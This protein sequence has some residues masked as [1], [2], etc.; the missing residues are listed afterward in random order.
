[1]NEPAASNLVE[2][3]VSEL[4]GALKVAIEDQFGYVRVRGEVSGYRGPHGSGHVYFSIK[5]ASAKI[6]AVIWRGVFAR[7]RVKPQEGMEVIASG[8]ITTFP[9]KS[10]YQILV[11]RIEP[12]GIGALMALLEDRRRRLAA[13]GLFDA[14]RKQ[15]IPY[16][17]TIVGVITSPS[18]AVI[19]DIL[20][21]IADRFPRRVLIWPV[22]VQGETSADEIVA[23]LAGFNGLSRHGPVPRPDVLILA[24]GGGSLEDLLSFNDEGVV[25][26]AAD[27]DIP[28]IAAVGHESDWTLVDYAADLRAPTPTGAA[29]MCV[30]VRSELLHKVNDIGRR[31]IAAGLRDLKRRRIELRS[32]DRLLPS[33]DE[34][35]AIPRQRFDRAAGRSAAA[36]SNVLTRRRATL[37][38]LAARL[39]PY[40]P[41]TRLARLSERLS[42]LRASLARAP[43]AS[44]ASRRH[45][46]DV[47]LARFSALL[48]GRLTLA[49][50]QRQR[51]IALAGRLPA[52]WS[53]RLRGARATSDNLGKLLATLG[54]RHVLAR[55]FVL[56]RD[57]AGRPLRLASQLAAEER[58]DLEFS[59]GHVEAIVGA[60][61]RPVAAPAP[62]RPAR[63][64]DQ[65]QGQLF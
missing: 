44:L 5:D 21:R 40:A 34:L 46:Q 2:F 14:A 17:P 53:A 30:P 65:G 19:R 56:V 6:D 10:S 28:L 23:A 55:G 4:A 64:P 58:L 48:R 59:D 3:T 1:M 18:G 15:L 57:T 45:R 39:A 22:R 13:E 12:A 32:A 63:P 37:L 60:T 54:Y 61:A 52:A 16:L 38:A 26:A 49:R 47:V 36:L 42:A 31:L 8:K 43:K 9:G 29:E 41:Q 35:V 50:D 20:H 7:M 62:R 27:S 24:R 33:P 51:L 11:E 25:R